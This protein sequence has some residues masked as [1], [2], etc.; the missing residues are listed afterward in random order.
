MQDIVESIVWSMSKWVHMRKEFNDVDLFELD[1]FWATIFM[2][3]WR[4]KPLQKISRMSP[5]MG[6]L[7]LNFDGSF[8]S[9][10][11]TVWMDEYHGG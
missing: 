6:V 10:Q 9:I 11:R 2:G 3:S 5:P 4:V 1:Q 8:V 7:K